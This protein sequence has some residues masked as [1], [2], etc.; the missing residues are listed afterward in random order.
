MAS[1]RPTSAKT[2]Q[3]LKLATRNQVEASGGLEAAAS[4]TRV[5]KT[6]L[7]YCQ[8]NAHPDRFMPIDV[9]ADL[10]IGSGSC[11]LVCELT[12]VVGCECVPSPRTSTSLCADFKA[13]GNYVSAV[14]RDFPAL[15]ASDRMDR[16]QIERLDRDLGLV[17]EAAMDARA[18][19]RSISEGASIGSLPCANDDGVGQQ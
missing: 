2:R 17:I 6:E 5:G 11:G 16:R 10:M 12:G 1:E 14:F 8:S 13:F 7:G 9:A 19:L 18:A 3:Y 4:W 15:L